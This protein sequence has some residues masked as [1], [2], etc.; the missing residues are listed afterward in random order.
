LA[1]S[2]LSI[3]MN[4]DGWN[5]EGVTETMLSDDGALQHWQASLPVNASQKAFLR[6]QVI[7]P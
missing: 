5:T 7:K 1:L 4:P 6:L 3:L 2:R